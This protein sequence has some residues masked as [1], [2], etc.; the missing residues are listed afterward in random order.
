MKTK[1]LPV[2]DLGPLLPAKPLAHPIV[3]KM[4]DAHARYYDATSDRSRDALRRSIERLGAQLDEAF[5]QTYM[6]GLLPRP[7]DSF[8]KDS[9]LLNFD[10]AVVEVFDQ[11]ALNRAR[12]AQAK[13]I[14][15]L[16][17]SIYRLP[18]ADL[19]ALRVGDHVAVRRRTET[20]S[21]H[22]A[23]TMIRVVK[24]WPK[25]GP[26]GVHVYTWSGEPVEP[27]AKHQYITDGHN[28]PR[29]LENFRMP[30]FLHAHEQELVLLPDRVRRAWMRLARAVHFPERAD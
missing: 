10:K 13:N 2:A 4:R 29:P 30:G 22:A 14:E 24:V 7:G 8:D 11:R 19:K 16:L 3:A 9:M 25:R 1:T 17:A 18:A 5:P 26:V 12:R 27:G 21:K 20:S 6:S 15:R 28:R 23:D